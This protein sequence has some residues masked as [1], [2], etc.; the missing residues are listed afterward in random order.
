MY[1]N[2][3]VTRMNGRNRL[4]LGVS[5]IDAHMKQQEEEKRVR[6]E[7]ESLG[8]IAALSP[9]YMV[10]YTVDPVT[11]KYTQYSPSSE[12]EKFGL[13][14]QGEDFFTD[15]VS[16]APKAIAPKD[17]ERHL[18]VMTRENMLRDIRNS[19]VFI[20]HYRMIMDGR[21]VPTSLKATLIKESDGEKIILG[22]TEDA[23]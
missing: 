13:A 20:H 5:I 2:M 17:M 16:D 15:V 3:K 4:I 7:K 19:G 21:I 9:N 18:R 23:E 10:L 1:V 14:S 12:F 8:R 22:V 11:G 6:Q